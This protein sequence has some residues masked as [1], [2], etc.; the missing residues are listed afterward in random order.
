MNLKSFFGGKKEVARPDAARPE[1]RRQHY[2]FA[3]RLMPQVA[4]QW[5]ANTVLLLDDPAAAP[6]FLER[7]WAE[8]AEGLPPNELVAPNELRASVHQ[9]DDQLAAVIAL[10]APIAVTE[11]Y[12]VAIAC[13]I[14]PQPPA[15]KSEASLENYRA[16]LAQ[17]PV[18]YWTLEWGF[19]LDQPR[20]VLGMWTNEGAHLNLGD[21]PAPDEA[22]F[23]EAI[24]G[25]GN[26]D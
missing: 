25:R 26:Q 6:G 4:H 18:Q 20:T 16:G 15:D 9:S 10:P 24:F 12:F 8:C 11:A 17:M 14:P 22:A 13:Q 2:L 5:G 19:T 3:H 1:A 7:R 21:G 23:V